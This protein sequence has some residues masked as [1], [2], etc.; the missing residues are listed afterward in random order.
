MIVPAIVGLRL[1]IL[2][3]MNLDCAKTKSSIMSVLE[4]LRFP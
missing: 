3:T 2:G 4:L 1:P